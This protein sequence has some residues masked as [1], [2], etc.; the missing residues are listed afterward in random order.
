MP[1]SFQQGALRKTEDIC[2]HSTVR[3]RNIVSADY[4]LGSFQP[5]R[6]LTAKYNIFFG[7]E[8]IKD[9]KHDV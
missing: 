5:L 9:Y 8:D 3:L 6:G 2:S 1:N 7:R 4:Y